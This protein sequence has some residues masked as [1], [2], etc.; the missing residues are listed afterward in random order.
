MRPTLPAH[1][2]A[3]PARTLAELQNIYATAPVGLCCVDTAL[4]YI[5]INDRLASYNGAPASAH[6]GRTLREMIPDVADAIEPVY[7]HVLQ[8]GEPVFDQEL[9]GRT[10]ASP[11]VECTWMCTYSPVRDDEG[12]VTAVNTVVVDVTDRKAHERDLQA[13]NDSLRQRDDFLHVVGDQLPRA[14]FFR[15]VH[16]PDGSFRFTYVSAGVQ[17]V[18]GLT[19]D[20]LLCRPTAFPDLI[21]AE[22]RP[23]FFEA[24]ACSITSFSAFDEVIRLQWPDGS[25][26]WGHFRASARPGD[27]GCVICEGIVLNT[28]SHKRAE[29]ALLES[30]ARNR[31]IMS[32]LPDMIFLLSTDGTYLDVHVRDEQQLFVP[33]SAFI[34]KTI[35][36]VLPPD[37][38]RQISQCIDRV[39]AEGSAVADYALIVNGERRHYETRMVPCGPDR[40]LSIVRDV[41]ESK[42]AQH[43]V[44]HSRLELAHISRV[45][46][47]G[48]ITA[49]I[50]HELNQPLTAIL[51]NAQAAKHALSSGRLNLHDISEMLSDIIE[52]D[53]RAGDVIRRLRTWLSRDQFLPQPL[54]LNQVILDV[55]HLIRSELIMR[56][57][58]LTLELESSLPEVAADRVQVQQVI[59]NLALNGFEAMENRVAAE[60]HLVIRTSAAGRGV[61]C[62]VRDRGTGIAPGDMDRLFDAFFSTKPTGLG[63]GLRICASIISAHG[64]RI[65]AANNDDG[66]ATFFFTL[67]GDEDE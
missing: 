26:H 61:Q 23:R 65:W 22:D 13:A 29:E 28:T 57:V 7:R 14:M 51:S 10:A 48:E 2:A 34:G 59:L 18:M 24:M 12:Y 56:H 31:A 5:S 41:T 55:E 53:R 9:V 4:R 37:L 40:I 27:D 3:D 17:A 1:S 35:A 49:S 44:Q 60:R 19:A 52:A 46:V 38:A 33:P 54:D 36:E 58:R 42:R 25:V 64:G 67:P 6:I 16:D 21:V 11:D 43:E 8:T 20:A 62:A 30:E 15:L 50:A 66:G 39:L 47:L 45:T 32:A 63:I